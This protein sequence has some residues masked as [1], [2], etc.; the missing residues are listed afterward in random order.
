MGTDFTIK[1]NK[2]TTDWLESTV[3]WDS[4]VNHIDP[5][6]IQEFSTTDSSFGIES[7]LVEHWIEVG[8]SLNFG[9]ILSAEEGVENNFVEFYSSETSNSPRL[10]IVFTDSSQNLDTLSYQVT[11]DAIVAKNND[12]LL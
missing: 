12:R 6:I 4:I 11:K 3:T 1:I 2:L 7:E 9:I 5:E 10:E 8:D